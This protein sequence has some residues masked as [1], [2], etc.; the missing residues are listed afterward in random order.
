LLATLARDVALCL[1]RHEGLVP[2]PGLLIAA[3]GGCDSSALAFLVEHLLRQGRLA[4]PVLLGH[5]DH[6]LREDH[7]MVAERV[8][9]LARRLGLPFAS[10]SLALPPAASEQQQRERRYAALARL[11]RAAGVGTILTAHQ[12]D[13]DLETILF[14][15]LRGTGP[16]GLAGIPALRRLDPDLIV[17]RP[18]LA[19]RRAELAALC[20]EFGLQP[21]DDPLN[22]DRRY[23][24]NRLRHELIPALRA[25]LGDQLDESIANLQRTARSAIELLHA[26][27]VRILRERTDWPLPWRAELDLR[28]M[29]EADLPFLE[30]AVQLARER[31]LP[32]APAPGWNWTRRVAELLLGPVGRRVSGRGEPLLAERAEQRLLLLLTAAAGDAPEHPILLGLEPVRF[33]TTEWRLFARPRAPGAAPPAAQHWIA[34]L[35]VPP[36]QRLFA[37]RRRPGDCIAS[38]RPGAKRPL[39]RLLQERRVPRFDRDR[40]PL[41]VGAG[42]EPRWFPGGGKA[43][44]AEPAAGSQHRTEV[45]ALRA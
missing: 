45:V 31:L 23:A 10:E 8:E 22:A 6:G 39:A 13:D 9:Q 17:V 41:V 27:G 26:Q 20:R 36:D 37:R 33:G 16:R 25:Q 14:R 38:E 24:R 42:D 29:A 32:G 34:V 11:A 43:A 2:A 1:A 3:S 28:G 21:D 4:G 18:L 15:L 7:A 40:L 30:I 35:A 19:A 44:G 5:V 12:A